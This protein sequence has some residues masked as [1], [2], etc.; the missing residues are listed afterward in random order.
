MDDKN[1]IGLVSGTS[2]DG[3]DA[4]IVNIKGFGL[5]SKVKLVDFQTFPYPAK[6]KKEILK[7]SSPD[8][9]RVDQICSL[10]FLLGKVFAGAALKIIKKS[11]MKKR[12]IALIGSHG[13]TIY[14]MPHQSSKKNAKTPSTLQIGEPSIIAEMTGITTVSDFRP[15][16]IAAGGMGAPL[17]PYVHYLLFRN[18]K[19]TRAVHNIGGISNV[20]VIPDNNDID[21]VI[22][23]DTGPGNMAIDGI[24][25]KLTRNHK[26]YDEMGEW[27]SKGKVDKRLFDILMN[28]PYIT[29]PPPKSTGREE[30]G[31]HFIDR[32]LKIAEKYNIS[33]N[34]LI[35]T[36][37]AFTSD[38][39]ILNYKL[40]VLP[41]FNLSRIIFG[42][43]GTKNLTLLSWLKKGL[44]P[45]SI[46]TMEDYHY[47][48]DALEAMAFGILAN[49][50]ISGIP[51]NLPLVTGAKKK[52]I[53]GKIVPGKLKNSFLF[54]R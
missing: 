30:F 1:V 4:A 16:D 42:G 43:G 3:V 29:K 26:K 48:S 34:D 53:L 46:H 10:N 32:I 39:I 7:A 36:V 41:R 5:N 38:S 20:T 54:Q 27:A 11:K 28:H 8:S 2:A 12:D 22:A 19:E 24:I 9:S 15:R 37:T 33:D 21:K 47:S 50:T 23:F 45:L 18:K 31:N 14:H 40:F 44:A 49:E 35:S 25:S 13:Q 52:T 6:I 51:N 17:T